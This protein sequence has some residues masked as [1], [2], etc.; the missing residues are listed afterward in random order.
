MNRETIRIE[1]GI[2]SVPVT[3]KI[4]MTQYEIANLF[5][6]F[7]SKVSANIR[8]ILKSGVFWEEDVCREIKTQK[9]STE[10]YNLEMIIALSFRIKSYRTEIF[11]NW[12][13]RKLTT[14]PVPQELLINFQSD[15]DKIILN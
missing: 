13:V 15:I 6:C 9:G 2:V 7:I 4:W 1:N 3:N 8:A 5:D 11:R 14:I 10:Q 12:M